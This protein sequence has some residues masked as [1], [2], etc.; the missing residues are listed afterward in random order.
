MTVEAALLGVP[1]M[2][3]V[4]AEQRAADRGLE[5]QGLSASPCTPRRRVPIRRRG[6]RPQHEELARRGGRRVDS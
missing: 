1:T 3:I 4:A 2:R 5:S 6:A